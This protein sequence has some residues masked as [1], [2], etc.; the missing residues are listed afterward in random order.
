MPNQQTAP[1]PID[2]ARD[3]LLASIDAIE[4]IE[5]VDLDQACGRIAAETITST[6][7][8]PRTHMRRLT[9]MASIL[10]A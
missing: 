9:A 5:T 4:G 10:P 2:L 6:I 7:D 3:E 8:L 1:I